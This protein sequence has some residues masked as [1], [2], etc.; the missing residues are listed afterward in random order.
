MEYRGID[1]SAWQGEIDWKKVADVGTEFAIIRITEAGNNV[2]AYFERN[3]N[4]CVDYGI[5]A[6]VYKFSYA[7]SVAAVRQEAERVVDI[8]RER[9]LRYPVFLTWNTAINAA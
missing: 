5:P 1:V 6:G 8:L 2:D 9:Q 7:L 3:Y 4:G